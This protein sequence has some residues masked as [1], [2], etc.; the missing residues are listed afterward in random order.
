MKAVA[1]GGVFIEYKEHS[2]KTGGKTVQEIDF[3]L[4]DAFSNVSFGG[5]PAAVCPLK[6]WLP[7][8]TLLKM[9]Q[10]HNQS[11]TAFSSV[12]KGH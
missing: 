10:Q 2:N 9:A 4:V 1:G 3:Y 11:E 12:R 5:N 6:A 7:D 8:E